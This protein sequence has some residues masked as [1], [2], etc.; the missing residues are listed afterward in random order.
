MLIRNNRSQAKAQ[1]Q[2]LDDIDHEYLSITGLPDFTSASAKLIFGPDS[3]AIKENR[4]G[5]KSKDSRHGPD[6][7]N[8]GWHPCKP[9]LELAQ[10]I[11]PAS[12]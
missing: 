10:T 12:F 4:Y 6:G 11:W 2:A 9:F 8:S 3:P 5:L 7:Q 1:L